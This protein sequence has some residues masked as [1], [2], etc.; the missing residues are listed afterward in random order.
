MPSRALVI[1]D[2]QND[3]LPGGALPVPRGDEVVA[4]ANRASQHFDLVVAT[5]DWHPADHVSFAGNHPGH[6][7]GEVVQTAAGLQQRL[8]P[9]HCVQ[10]TRGAALAAGLDLSRIAYVVHK[11]TDSHVDSYSAFFDNGHHHA[12]GL[13]R[14]L[15]DAGVTEIFLLG[16]ATDYCV[17]Y[18]AR[19]ALELG[20]QVG[21]I[22]DGCRGIDASAIENV[23]TELR[24]RGARLVTSDELPPLRG[25]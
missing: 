23:L 8:W 14:Y 10:G 3:F 2:V 20:F 21:V 12:T 22:V 17:A 4:V 9:V 5:Q 19:D 25:D 13:D 24:R 11:G 18:S 1:I 7:A 6:S 15:R 16:L